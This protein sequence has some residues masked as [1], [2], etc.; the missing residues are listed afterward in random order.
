VVPLLWPDV[1]AWSQ[2]PD[3]LGSL[4]GGGSDGGRAPPSLSELQLLRI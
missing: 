2:L 4:T 1:A 3:A